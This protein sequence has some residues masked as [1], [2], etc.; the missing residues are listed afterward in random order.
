MRGHQKNEEAKTTVNRKLW[1]LKTRKSRNACNWLCFTVLQKCSHASMCHGHNTHKSSYTHI[2]LKKRGDKRQ[3]SSHG[4]ATTLGW[5][6]SKREAKFTRKREEK[7][8]K[9]TKNDTEI[10]L[11][12]R[13]KYN[14]QNRVKSTCRKIFLCI[15]I[16]RRRI[17]LSSL[18]ELNPHVEF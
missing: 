12:R 5:L 9:K 18:V 1:K 4:N 6:W 3:M 13:Q 16:G 14:S 15:T 11:S 10:L 17:V 8:K 7:T 2:F